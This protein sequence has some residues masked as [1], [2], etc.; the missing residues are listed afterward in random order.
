MNS[1]L[2]TPLSVGPVTVKNRIVM[3]PMCQ[4]SAENGM[5]SDWH[6]VHYPARAIGGS[7]LVTL[8]ATAVEAR[9]RISPEDLGIW[10]DDHVEGLSRLARAIADSGAVPGI[11]LA[12]AGRKASTSRPFDGFGPLLPDNGGWPVIG[13]SA[14]AYS[15]NYQI[16]AAMSIDDIQEVQEAFILAARRA[17]SAGFRVIEIH[18]A[19]GYLI[20]SFLSP[21]ANRRDDEYGDGFDGRTRFLMELAREIRTVCADQ[22]ALFVRISAD[23]WIEGGWSVED[24][25]ALA[26]RLKTVPIDMLHVSSGGISPI[27]KPSDS[28]R[29]YQVSLSERIRREAKI[30]TTAVGLITDARQA[31]AILSEGKADLVALGRELLR[32]PYWPQ[33]AAETLNADPPVPLQYIRAWRSR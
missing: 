2:F 26:D 29:D 13:P 18:A 30:A 12:H 15:E 7:G 9:G 17:V 19:H 22:A 6:L 33:R 32:D 16:P 31:E 4:Y 11:Q 23:D 20:H 14:I 10:S 28:S 24:S 1:L 27:G 8:E 5:V 25:I 3:A 21:A